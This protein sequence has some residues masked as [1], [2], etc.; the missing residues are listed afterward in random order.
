MPYE[1]RTHVNPHGGL[2]PIL[3]TG[4]NGGSGGVRTHVNPHG[5]L[6][7]N[8]VLN[9]TTIAGVRTHVNPHGGLKLYG[10]DEKI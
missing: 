1:V 2:K 5:G 3:H 6:K 4:G 8:V 9:K 7:R 10:C